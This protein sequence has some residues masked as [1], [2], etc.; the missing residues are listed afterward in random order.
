M[1]GCARL[2]LIGPAALF[3]ALL[4]A[5]SAAYALATFPS[6]ATLWRINLGLFGV[7]QKADYVLSGYVDV[8]YFQLLFVGL[9]L[10]VM[11]GC[12]F[13]FRRTLLLAIA[14]N[15]SFVY[16]SFLLCSWYMCEQSWRQ[17]SLTPVSLMFT[18]P[19]GPDLGVIGLLLGASLLSVVVS[20][21]SYLRVCLAGRDAVSVLSVSRP[22]GRRRGYAA[23]D[24]LD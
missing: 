18:V 23:A 4:G 24:R 21:M 1:S 13:V 7:F 2:Q 8:A 9:P 16:A 20:H 10:V 6:S 19:A 11:A 12:G 5:D 3:A 15:L 14:C 22:A 17:A